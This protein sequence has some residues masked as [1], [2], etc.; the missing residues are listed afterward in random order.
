MS[1]KKPFNEAVADCIWCYFKVTVDKSASPAKFGRDHWWPWQSCPLWNEGRESYQVSW[2][3]N[4]SEEMGIVKVDKQLKT[5]CEG[6]KE[7]RRWSEIFKKSVFHPAGDPRVYLNEDRNELSGERITGWLRSQGRYNYRRKDFGKVK[8]TGIQTKSSR[9]EWGN[10]VSIEMGGEEK[11]VDPDRWFWHWNGEGFLSSSIFFYVGDQKQ[12]LF[13]CARET[14][15]PASG[16][17][18]SQPQA[19]DCVRVGKKEGST[20]YPEKSERGNVI[21]IIAF[22]SLKVLEIC[23]IMSQF[24]IT[25]PDILNVP[26]LTAL[27]LFC[28]S[29]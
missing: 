5:L 29:C 8:D 10:T 23:V 15:K 25:I 24:P 20:F 13:S 7:T 11:R 27:S 17:T 3:K 1:S 12:N 2:E 26:F 16:M 19:Y 9:I 4:A 14:D 21:S 22:K 6:S 18:P 28:L